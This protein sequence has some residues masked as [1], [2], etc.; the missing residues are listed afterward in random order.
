MKRFQGSVGRCLVSLRGIQLKI[1]WF[2]AM[3]LLH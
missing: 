3:R 1:G 2:V